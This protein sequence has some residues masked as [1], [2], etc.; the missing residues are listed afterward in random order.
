MAK[1]FNVNG[2]TAKDEY[3]IAA[4][5]HATASRNRIKTLNVILEIAEMPLSIPFAHV[6]DF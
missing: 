4:I 3:V 6:P 2:V 1:T 5:P